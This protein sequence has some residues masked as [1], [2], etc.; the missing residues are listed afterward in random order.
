MTD[1]A[2]RVVALVTFA[3]LAAFAAVRIELTNS[4]A[5]FLPKGEGSVLEAVSRRLADSQL[6]R[7]MVLSIG[8]EGD[9]DPVEAAGRLARALAQHPEVEWVQGGLDEAFLETVY[10]LYFERRAYFAAGD[11]ARSVPARVEDAALEARAARLKRQLASPSSPLVARA[12]PADPL[13]LFED[14]IETVRGAETSLSLRD[15]QLVT[16]DGERAIVLAGLR[17]SPFRF[18]AQAPLVDFIRDTFDALDAEAGGGLVLEWSG[19][20]RIAVVSERSMRDDVNRIS[21]VSI[22][23]VGALF[24]FLFRSWRSLLV[25]MFPPLAG[26]VLATALSVTVVSPLH[27]VTVGFGVAL[28]GVSID[29]PIHVLNHHALAR[30]PIPAWGTLASIRPSLVLGAAT[31]IVSFSALMLTDLPGIAEMGAFASVGI[32]AALLTTLFALPAFLRDREA[33]PPLHRKVALALEHAVK[34][35]RR[36]RGPLLLLPGVF[37]VLSLVGV[38]QI[39]W[40]DDPAALTLL[41]RDLAAEDERVR[42]AISEYDGARF[43]VGLAPDADAALVLND[44]IWREVSDAIAA[45]ELSGARSLHALLPSVEHQ[46]RSAE[47]WRAQADLAERIDRSFTRAG[48]APG[49]F[50]PFEQH[51][52]ELPREPLR[53]EDLRGTPLQKLLDAMLVPLDDGVAVITYLRGLSAPEALQ[54]RLSDIEGAH[55]FDRHALLRDIYQGH[56]TTTLR[57]IVAGSL[58]V[59]LVLLVRYRSLRLATTAFLPAALVATATLGVFGTLGIGVNLLNVVALILVMGMGV[60][61]GIFLVDSEFQNERLGATLLSVLFSC[62]TTVFVFGTLSL[63]AHPALR[64]IGLTTGIGILMAFVLAPTLLVL[65]SRAPSEAEVAE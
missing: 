8:S 56:R 16:R 65:G 6:S 15:G 62:L 13:G 39:D 42:A 27:A 37:V 9:A 19:V 51:L 63:S 28:V 24:F 34:G 64:S 33:A 59:W 10:Q 49:A 12:A 40:V 1:R 52:R 55:Y 53:P 4:I 31:T 29:Y 25:A 60:D 35:A 38:P 41:D 22:V 11:P 18:A 32:G 20:N 44:R 46:R 17:S 14:L 7:R 54:A 36:Y 23:G 48:F 2:I 61:Y 43:V 57:L 47:A 45:G 26:V 3:L 21:L 30:A 50:G 58:L 5:H